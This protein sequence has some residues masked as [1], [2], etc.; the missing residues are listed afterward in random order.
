MSWISGDACGILGI[1]PA[2]GRTLNAED[3]ARRNLVAVLSYSFWQSRFGGS[4][5]V[6]GRSILASSG[7]RFQIVG[8][9]GKGFNGLEPG[10]LTDVWLPLEI[11]HG[12][13]R[14]LMNPANDFFGV[15]GKLRPGITPE[16]LRQALQPVFAAARLAQRRQFE[17]SGIPPGEMPR[18][19]HARLK[20]ESSANGHA[21]I[22]R[23]QFRQP[24]WILAVVA[25]TWCC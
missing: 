23:L 4:P 10:Y 25:R 1:P 15:W 7:R 8:V 5:D 21:N 19:L 17:E 20:V 18:I 13:A 16:R 6:L 2:L 11:A 22:V 14:D 3:S 9:A 12:D 24:L